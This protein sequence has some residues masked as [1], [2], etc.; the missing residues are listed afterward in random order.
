MDPVS[1]AGIGLSISSLLL[2]AFTGCVRGYQL[3]AE[4]E[5]MPTTYHHLRVRLRIEQARLL[6]WGEKVGLVEELLAQPSRVIQLNRNLV[7]DIL[8]EV[9]GLFRSCVKAHEKFD[10]LV[11]E[12]SNSIAVDW[13]A[14]DTKLP[15]GTNKI[16]TKILRVLE[17]TPQISRRLQWAMVEHHKF[18]DLIQKLIGYN[19]SIESILDQ[20][21][22]DQLRYMQ[23]QT[24]M[25]MLQL[26]SKVDE[27][28]DLSLAIR[29]TTQSGSQAN[30]STPT[31]SRSSTLG[32]DQ[33]D[34]HTSFASLTD[35]KMQQAKIEHGGTSL[36]P[37]PINKDEVK[38]DDV[39]AYRSDATYQ[40]KQVWVEWK[41]YD[42]D[43]NPE[44]TWNKT[45]EQRTRKLATLLCSKNKPKEFRA[46]QC[47]GY[48]HDRND[49]CSRYGFVYEKPRAALVTSKP[50]SLLDL[51]S[52][53]KEPSLSKRVALAH[54]LCES[55]MYLQSVNWLHKGFRCDSVIFFPA[56]D[57]TPSQLDYAAPILSGFDYARPD[58]PEE[59]TERISGDIEHEI[60]RHPDQ[61][62]RVS[63]RSKKSH[64]IYSL[65]IVLIEIA[66][67]KHI[68]DIMDIDIKQKGARS[69]LR[70]IR[71][72]LLSE[73]EGFLE[74]VGCKV[75][76]VYREVVRKCISGGQ[77]LGTFESADE[78]QANI[79]AE[80]QRVFSEDLLGQLG[81]VKL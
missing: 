42:A 14:S 22:F 36:T 8:L 58:L 6:N 17:K 13:S 29:L 76:E 30:S 37:V 47:L 48:F 73:E 5:G 70:K 25:I 9:Q 15:V 16:L 32:V 60:Y 21:A 77:A 31:I 34:Q 67:W 78:T 54:A 61:V 52:S 44:S 64:D 50:V 62:K 75:G 49:E 35:F 39:S 26:T 45:I 12:Q 59:V 19:D 65:G 38:V 23:S 68:Y 41:A 4:A 55:L 20:N 46:P 7:L 63:S 27:L 51:F 57:K 80:M 40:G 2:Q 43:V 10:S 1:A 3:F 18:A 81:S 56:Q 28:K 71:Y 33:Q 69:K 24:H 66:H 72:R 53:S 74:G 11:P 79:G